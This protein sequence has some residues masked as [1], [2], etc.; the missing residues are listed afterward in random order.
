M[1]RHSE[2]TRL[3]ISESLRKNLGR[4]CVLCNSRF[5]REAG[6]SQQIAKYCP[7]CRTKC[8]DCGIREMEKGSFCLECKKNHLSKDELPFEKL[9]RNDVRKERLVTERGHVCENCGFSRWAEQPIP[10]ELDHVNGDRLD[11]RKENC[12]LLCPNCHA[13]TPTWKWRNRPNRKN[14]TPAI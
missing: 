3:K 4:T 2:E 13:Q 8:R 12:R 11:N 6:V 7:S 10:L 1:S 9:W 14:K 5:V